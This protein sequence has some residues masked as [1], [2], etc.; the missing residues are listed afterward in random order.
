MNS[1][2]ASLLPDWKQMTYWLEIILLAVFT[3][4]LSSASVLSDLELKGM[5]IVWWPAA[6]PILIY[7]SR[8]VNRWPAILLAYLSH[9][10]FFFPK[11]DFFLIDFAWLLALINTME[12]IPLVLLLNHLKVTSPFFRWRDTLLFLAI[13]ILPIG[14]FTAAVAVSLLGSLNFESV[15]I[16]TYWWYAGNLLAVLLI[17]PFFVSYQKQDIEN[18]APRRILIWS[19]LAILSVVLGILSFFPIFQLFS[20][21]IPYSL[22]FIPVYLI[23]CLKLGVRGVATV[24]FIGGTMAVLAYS[25]GQSPWPSS[26]NPEYLYLFWAVMLIIPTLFLVAGA[27]V[28]KLR[29]EN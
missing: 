2:N 19:I 22:I 27:Y 14:L 20:L 10:Y 6:I 23:S 26:E 12:A 5:T 1:L 16:E 29:Y 25:L 24:N 9:Y 13:G 7:W 8:G 11:E 17:V 21:Q 15:I 18:K 28:D 4:L 3:V